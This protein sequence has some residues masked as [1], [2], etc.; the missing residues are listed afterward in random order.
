MNAEQ[1]AAQHHAE[2]PLPDDALANAVAAWR[3]GSGSRDGV[4]AALE[5]EAVRV[6]SDD[7]RRMAAEFRAD[8]GAAITVTRHRVTI[9]RS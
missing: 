9:I 7:Y 6:G 3:D 4:V 8:V 5:G 2:R 1:I